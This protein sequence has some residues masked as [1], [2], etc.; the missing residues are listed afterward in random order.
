MV[1]RGSSVGRTGDAP[2]Y[3]MGDVQKT[4]LAAIEAEWET[5]PAPASY[6]VRYS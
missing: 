3:E 5:Q 1:A 4:K 2:G 6:P